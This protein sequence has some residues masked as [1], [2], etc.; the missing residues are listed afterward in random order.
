MLPSILKDTGQLH[1]RELPSPKVNHDEAA[2]P[3]TKM[4]EVWVTEGGSAGRKHSDQERGLCIEGMAWTL[5]LP[6]PGDSTQ[7]P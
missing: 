2:Y 6:F 3:W 7:V 5:L 4:E 1:R